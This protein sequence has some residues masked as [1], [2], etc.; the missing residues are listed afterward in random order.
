MSESNLNHPVEQKTTTSPE[1]ALAAYIG[2][3]VGDALGWPF[4]G[5]AANKLDARKW[6]GQFVDWKKRSGSRFSPR[7]EQIDAGAYSDDT[8]LILAI[9]RSRAI[10]PRW[11]E[12][13]A[14]VELPFWTCYERGGGG[15]TKR[16]AVSWLAGVAPWDSKAKDVAKR[17]FEAGGNGAAMRVLPHCVFHARDDDFS[18]LAKNILAD[19]V[20]THGHPRALVGALAFGY[21]LWNAFKRVDTLDY[22]SLLRRCVEEATVWGKLPDISHHWPSWLPATQKH[23]QDFN[24]HWSLAVDEVLTLCHRAIAGLDGGVL[25]DDMV[26]MKELGGLS[27]KTNG[28][29]TT[30]AVAAL[31]FASRYAASPLEGMRCAAASEGADTDT[32]ASMTA[33]LLGVINGMSWLQDYEGKLQDAAYIRQTAEQLVF[34]YKTTT[35]YS[36]VT[37]RNLIEF[38]RQ[39]EKN[40]VPSGFALPIGLQVTSVE[41]CQEQ[42]GE[43]AAEIRIIA[44]DAGLTL[45]IPSSQTKKVES[46]KKTELKVES[47]DGPTQISSS[48]DSDFEPAIGMTLLVRD[49]GKSREFYEK[50]LGLKVTGASQKV[51]RF[52]STL[53][54]REDPS[55]PQFCG[56]VKL[57]VNVSD[58]S[59]CFERMTKAGVKSSRIVVRGNARSFEC[60][61]PSGYVIEVFERLKTYTKS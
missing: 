27:P 22:G 33:S 1:R 32:L 58:V 4:E 5:R 59:S 16:A 30:T 9:S 21:I 2:A 61:D 46:S 36:Q 15:A 28:A 38:K 29:G 3:A 56:G 11:W 50:F 60:L 53:A 14:R 6:D 8:Q 25:S 37:K 13:F 49:L 18:T 42:H 19:G 47:L 45:F 31:Y 57:F 44:T 12:Y 52:S 35:T 51:V 54:L 20:I 43:R 41:C 17:Y 26:I 48:S 55:T 39:L 40:E 23:V 7:W 10:G 34:M 24:G